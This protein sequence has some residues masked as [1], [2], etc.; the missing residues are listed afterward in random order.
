MYLSKV[1]VEAEGD[2]NQ[3][4]EGRAE[5]LK[6]LSQSHCPLNSFT[7]ASNARSVPLCLFRFGSLVKMSKIS[8]VSSPQ[9]DRK[10]KCSQSFLFEWE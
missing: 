7:F 1:Y 8:P 5:V 9:Q 6:R 10:Q 4:W 2:I 3:P